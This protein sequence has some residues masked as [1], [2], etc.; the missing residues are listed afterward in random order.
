MKLSVVIPAYNESARITK[1]LLSVS[2]FL[3]NQPWEYEILVVSDGSKDNTAE[4]VK[5]LSKTL[6]NLFLIDNKQNHGKGWVVRQGML[7]ASGDARLFMD[8]D[9]ST[10]IDQV[11]PMI[12][13]LQNGYDV[14]IGSI[15][16]AG[17]KIDEHAQWYR[18]FVGHWSKYLIRFVAGIWEIHDSQRGFKL[19]SASAA[20]RVFSKAVI[21]RFGF[22]IEILAMSKK[23]GYKIKELPVVW[24]NEGESKVSLKSYIEVFIDLLKIR[25]NL[26]SGKYD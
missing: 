5:H 12:D 13:C 26:W 6:K 7:K 1:T 24:V 14:V 9:N 15:E 10:S 18:R 4:V 2:E 20:Q 16:V 23:F 22:D 11:L 17:A 8:A 25:L 19:F 3:K 21:E